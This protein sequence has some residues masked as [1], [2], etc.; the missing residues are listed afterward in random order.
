VIGGDEKVDEKKERRNWEKDFEF[1]FFR[2]ELDPKTSG[3][4]KNWPGKKKRPGN[5]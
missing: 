1:W 3:P 5:E 2:K 4:K